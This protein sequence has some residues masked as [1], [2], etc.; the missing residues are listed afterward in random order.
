MDGRP[1]WYLLQMI[2]VSK[3]PLV[4][5]RPNFLWNRI[6]TERPNW[7]HFI[8]NFRIHSIS[9]PSGSFPHNLPIRWSQ[10]VLFSNLN[11]LG[12]PTQTKQQNK[13]KINKTKNN[14][15]ASLVESCNL[16]TYDSFIYLKPKS[17][18]YIVQSIITSENT[19][20]QFVKRCPAEGP[21]ALLMVKRIHRCTSA[22]PAHLSGKKPK[23]KGCLIFKYPIKVFP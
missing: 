5:S 3:A 15:N 2:W 8:T 16:F 1:I 11:H 23:N 9:R 19:V 22:F 21:P 4:N 14:T 7:C 6:D 20:K 17:M 18:W 10:H 13:K 12:I